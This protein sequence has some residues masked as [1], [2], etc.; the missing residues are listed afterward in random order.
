MSGDALENVTREQLGEG[1]R[2]ARE[3][4][5]VRTLEINAR[6]HWETALC[7]GQALGRILTT[8]RF[9][10]LPLPQG[11]AVKEAITWLRRALEAARVLGK[12]EE[13][14]DAALAFCNLALGLSSAKDVAA[15]AEEAWTAVR[16]A[17]AYLLLHAWSQEREARV[18]L[19]VA[20]NIALRLAEHT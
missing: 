20:L 19:S 3:A 18:A 12:G 1:F 17:S 7:I 2:L 11:E 8:M 5:K 14:L 16:E 15:G 4:A 10:L 13:L 9:D 6:H